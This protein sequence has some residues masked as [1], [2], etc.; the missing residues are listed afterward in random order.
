MKLDADV[1]ISIL[2]STIR[3]EAQKVVVGYLC[4]YLY[5]DCGHLESGDLLGWPK[6]FYPDSGHIW[7]VDHSRSRSKQHCHLARSI[8]SRQSF[9]QS[10]SQD[11]GKRADHV[12][13]CRPMTWNSLVSLVWSSAGWTSLSHC[14][15]GRI[16]FWLEEM[17]S[18]SVVDYLPASGRQKRLRPYNAIQTFRR[19]FHL[20]EISRS[21]R[22]GC[23]LIEGSSKKTFP[24]IW[25][26]E[27]ESGSSAIE[28]K[29]TLVVCTS[30]VWQLENVT[31][32]LASL[33]QVFRTFRG[34]EKDLMSTSL[35][36]WLFQSSSRTKIHS[37]QVWRLSE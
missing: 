6:E 35:E 32:S 26:A 7:W 8:Q 34:V 18:D 21:H 2:F 31:S 20:D 25:S 24:S 28:N 11:G 22:R 1:R 17:A 4:E 16:A 5:W 13:V 14:L 33:K 10:G 29:Q 23:S 27:K 15:R 19:T 37:L 9:R 12:Q 30:M 3:L 36:P